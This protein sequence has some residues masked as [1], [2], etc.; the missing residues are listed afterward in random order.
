MQVEGQH[1]VGNEVQ[2]VL[3]LLVDLLDRH[4]VLRPL[5]LAADNLEIG[6]LA[7]AVPGVLKLHALPGLLDREGLGGLDQAVDP[8]HVGD[9]A[10]PGFAQHLKSDSGFP[11]V[12]A[13]HDQLCA[14]GVQA[15]AA[16]DLFGVRQGHLQA[17][18]G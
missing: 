8:G 10:V 14:I 17:S 7:V 9:Q 3:V 13:G 1:E 6:D 11:V 12:E 15:V 4:D 16:P 2:A 18:I 5:Q